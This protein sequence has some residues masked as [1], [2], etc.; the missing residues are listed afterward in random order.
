MVLAKVSAKGGVVIPAT[1]RKGLGIRPGDRVH[2]EERDGEIVLYRALR[3]PIAD[4]WGMF[5]YDP[6]W[7]ADYF[8]AKAEDERLQD[9]KWERMSALAHQSPA[10]ASQKPKQPRARSA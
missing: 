4:S 5:P 9:A 7:E 3:D 8:A 1:I 2:V 6:N 10:P